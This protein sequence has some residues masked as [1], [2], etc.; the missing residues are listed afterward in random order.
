M[1]DKLVVISSYSDLSRLIP[2]IRKVHFRKFISRK[3]LEDVLLR[4]PKLKY[5]SVS[6]YASKRVYKFLSYVADKGLNIE[7][8]NS[9]SGRPNLLIR[10]LK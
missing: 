10:R 4:C 7:Y 8:S 6:R 9:N 1:N 2:G 5:I 3:L